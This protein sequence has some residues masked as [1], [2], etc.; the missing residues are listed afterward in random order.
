[1]FIF[2]SVRLFWLTKVKMIYTKTQ[3]RLLK[4]SLE[5]EHK[6]TKALMGLNRNLAALDA[7]FKG[8]EEALQ[9]LLNNDA[10]LAIFFNATEGN[11]S[12]VRFLIE[13][14]ETVLAATANVVKGDEKAE[15]WLVKH[16][17]EH[18]VLLAGA[19]KF[20]LANLPD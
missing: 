4:S 19:I 17:L 15:A 14:G 8:D 7:A 18:Y 13:Q 3:I 12:A 9:W 11:R 16:K 6:A 5:G 20:A 10:I 2:V 1:M